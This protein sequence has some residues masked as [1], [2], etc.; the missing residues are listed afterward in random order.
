[1]PVCVKE[2]ELARVDAIRVAQQESFGLTFLRNVQKDGFGIAMKKVKGD[3][4]LKI[5]PLM[6]LLPYVDEEGILRVGGRL[7]RANLPYQNAHL[8][9]LPRRHHITKLIIMDIHQS[10]GHMGKQFVLY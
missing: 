10:S 4:L 6:G 2:L 7:H 1:M 8:I 9:I 3:Q 5:K